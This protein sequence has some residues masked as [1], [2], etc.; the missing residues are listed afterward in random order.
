MISPCTASRAWRSRAGARPPGSIEQLV[1]ERR[2]E[3]RQV[4]LELVAGL[5]LDVVDETH[6][7]GAEEMQVHVAGHAMLLV[8]EV[9]VFEVG[10]RVAH[11]RLAR[12]EGFLPQHRAVA[13]DAAHAFQVRGQ[14][15]GVEH[16][17]HAAL[18][19]LRMRQQ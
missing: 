7:R 8:L 3:R 1:D 9:V 14:R 12:E 13:A 6:R 18:A 11:V 10:E 5:H 17:A 4:D 19:Q 2:A 16:R 15:A